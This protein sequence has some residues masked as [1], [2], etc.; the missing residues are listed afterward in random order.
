MPERVQLYEALT[1]REVLRYFAR[2]R[3][4]E[5]GRVEQMLDRVDLTAAADRRVGEYSKGMR[6]RL[7]LAQALL[8]KPRLL[9]LDEPVE[10][11]DPVGVRS[12]FAL[13][14]DEDVRTVLIASHLITE[15]SR[16]VDRVCIL[17]DGRI[18]ALGTVAEVAAG[19]PAPVVIHLHTTGERDDAIET[20]LVGAGASKV[21]RSGGSLVVEVAADRK[22]ALIFA[23]HELRDHVR[24]LRVEERGIEAY[25]S[26]DD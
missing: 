10:G 9:V 15:V 6:Q 13:L 8:G 11:L 20:L 22:T 5:D 24:D 19:V 25:W 14:R 17:A 7:N 4:A 1:G 16:H 23:L 21:A 18:R 2:L 26:S 3:G 12:L